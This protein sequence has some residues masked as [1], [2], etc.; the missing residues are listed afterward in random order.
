M[1][2]IA[3][4]SLLLLCKRHCDNLIPYR[5][6]L[7]PYLFASILST[8]RIENSRDLILRWQQTVS[9]NICYSRLPRDS[10]TSK[11]KIEWIWECVMRY[12]L[13]LVEHMN[14]L[15][16]SQKTVWFA[17][18]QIFGFWIPKHEITSLEQSARKSLAGSFTAAHSANRMLRRLMSI[19]SSRL[20]GPHSLSSVTQF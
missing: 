19:R 3:S 6:G 14:S 5:I 20:H 8:N 18:S 1:Q 2:S 17:T 7:L 10:R 12:L 9:K 16:T 15:Q 11:K 13:F 4:W